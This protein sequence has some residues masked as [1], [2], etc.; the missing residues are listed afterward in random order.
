MADDNQLGLR[1]ISGVERLENDQPAVISQSSAALNQ[2]TNALSL[3]PSPP[4]EDV[5]E[6]IHEI[7][8]LNRAI[9]ERELYITA[10]AKELDGLNA[11]VLRLE[12]EKRRHLVP[13]LAGKLHN[14][15]SL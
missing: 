1:I 6:R 15:A 11:R 14:S 2:S 3:R 4:E 13:K 5:I 7:A 10:I 8:A 12:T 9:S